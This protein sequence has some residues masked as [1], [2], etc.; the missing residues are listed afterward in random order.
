MLCTTRQKVSLHLKLLILIFLIKDTLLDTRSA[1]Q[2]G[3]RP[4]F[5]FHVKAEIFSFNG[6]ITTAHT[7]SLPFTIATRRNQVSSIGLFGAGK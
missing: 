7:L 3:K 1:G 2:T 5:Y 6:N 4:L